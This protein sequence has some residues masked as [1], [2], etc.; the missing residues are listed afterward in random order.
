MI[1][2]SLV[3]PRPA[4][5]GD[6]LGLAVLLIL[7]AVLLFDVQGAFIKYM[8]S[9]Y[10]VQQIAVF[11]NVFGLLPNLV[12]L[13]LSADWHR[14]GRKIVFPHWRVALMRGVFITVAQFCLYASLVR[15]EFATASA[16]VFA[17][18]L[19]ITMLSGP[20]LGHRVSVW[21]WLA[22]ITGFAGILLVMRPGSDVFTPYALLPIIAALGYATASITIRLI[23]GAVPSVLIN[24]YATVS[25]IAG[26]V[27]LMVLT[28]GFVPIAGL[29]DWL[30]F[31]G[32]GGVGSIA[33]LVM[34]MAYR[35]TLPGNVSPFEYFG[36][37]FS[38][39]IGWLVFDE[40]PFDRLFP[41][42]L[43]IV[44]GGLLIVW[45]ERRRGKTDKPTVN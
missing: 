43:L 1:R 24:L 12:I 27:A 10:P 18:P 5:P 28:T 29:N 16:L 9:T 34:I 42:V 15:L 21:Q 11:R 44:A 14:S 20:V 6:R 35:L 7:L 13:F 40:A 36:I 26:S 23:D 33:V 41:G 2:R 31:I 30:L 37:P 39:I 19:F 45:R 17:S 3:P 4:S 25:A 8:G 32:M 38:F 22:V